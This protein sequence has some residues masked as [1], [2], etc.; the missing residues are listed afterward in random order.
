VG[1]SLP[2]GYRLEVVVADRVVLVGSRLIGHPCSF[3][4]GLGA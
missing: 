2:D 4:E 3:G 1:Q